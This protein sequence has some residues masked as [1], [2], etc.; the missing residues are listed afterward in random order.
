MTRQGLFSLDTFW[1]HHV[2]GNT[3]VITLQYDDI[4]LNSITTVPKVLNMVAIMS[5][6][7]IASPLPTVQPAIIPDIPLMPIFT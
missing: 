5:H 1:G 7:V 3:I 4:A 6:P 2:N